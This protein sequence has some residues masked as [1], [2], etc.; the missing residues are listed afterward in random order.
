MEY[1]N[2][3]IVLLDAPNVF[4][5]YYNVNDVDIG[6]ITGELFDSTGLHKS[7]IFLMT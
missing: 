5:W 1:V 2:R 6:E 3:T 4:C 7:I